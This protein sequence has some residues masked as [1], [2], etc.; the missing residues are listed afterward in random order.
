MVASER[1]RP[2]A[3]MSPVVEG[4]AP[5]ENKGAQQSGTEPTA[6]SDRG[7]RLEELLPVTSRRLWVAALAAAIL[8]G[9]TLAYTLVTPRNVT[10]ATTGRVIGPGGVGLV[11]A[12]TAG[13][14][15]ANLLEPGVDVG[16]GDKVAEV[17]TPAGPVPQ[18]SQ[19][20]GVLLGYITSPGGPIEVGEW[21]AQVALKEDDPHTALILVL[22]DEAAQI[23]AG[24]AVSGVAENGDE[25]V[26]SIGDN[27]S[28]LLPP[29]VVQEGMGTTEQPDGP[30]IVIEVVLE[31]PGPVGWEFTATVMVSER[32]LFEQLLGLK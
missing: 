20:E 1:E 15:G 11:T 14:L 10:V 30:R 19:V 16:V 23:D 6:T 27:R 13:Q 24:M 29:W 8:I 31:E 3:A 32:T 4:G 28:T 12:N 21:L 9:A 26:G 25:I 18:Y 22:P 5:S 17:I 2:G 7:R